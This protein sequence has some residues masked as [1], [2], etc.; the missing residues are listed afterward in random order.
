[1]KRFSKTVNDPTNCP[2]EPNY[3]EFIFKIWVEHVICRDFT[4]RQIK[5]LGLIYLFSIHNKKLECY[6]P[7]LNSFEVSG[8]SRHKIKAELQKL[9]DLKVVEWNQETMIFKITTEVE[10]WKVDF[11]DHYSP[12]KIEQIIALN[13]FKFRPS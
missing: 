4:K 2:S 10:N 11:A 6:I 13:S 5:I 3:E 12:G 9:V 8:V 1:M 7:T